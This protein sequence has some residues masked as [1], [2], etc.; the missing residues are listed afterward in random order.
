MYINMHIC[1]CMCIFI[2]EYAWIY[3]YMYIYISAYA[4]LYICICIWMYVYL[5]GRPRND[6]PCNVM[7]GYCLGSRLPLKQN[8]FLGYNWKIQTRNL[9]LRLVYIIIDL[10][11]GNENLKYFVQIM[12]STECFRVDVSVCNI[13]KTS[14]ISFYLSRDSRFR[15]FKCIGIFLSWYKCLW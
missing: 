3:M 4:Y 1:L 8:S 12:T 5:R 2:G 6:W 14:G 10:L 13:L 7:Q 15:P 11:K 9:S